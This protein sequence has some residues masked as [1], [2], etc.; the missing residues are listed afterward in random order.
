MKTKAAELKLR[1]GLDG[2]GLD[3]PT[4]PFMQYLALLLQ[5]NKAFNLTA[6]RD[7]DEMVSR[8]ILDSLVI[9]PWLRGTH[10][11]DVGTGA[12]L[13][14]IPLALA[15]KDTTIV[16]LD[17]NGK[18]I[19]F[20]NEVKATLLLD[21]VHIIH[22]RAEDYRPS[23]QFDTVLTRAFSDIPHIMKWTNHLI[24]PDGLWLC[25][26][27]RRPLDEL[28]A[29]NNPLLIKDY[30]VDGVSGERCCVMIEKNIN[31]MQS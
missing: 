30:V 20:L 4:E 5:W 25:M 29:I 15:R 9:L 1:Q 16:L 13:P 12:G 28:T 17:S 10:W 24:K 8:H 2:L 22:A 7:L 3:L 31:A 26:K 27:G 14:G 18:K 21:F 19:R 6:V 23:Q 11:I